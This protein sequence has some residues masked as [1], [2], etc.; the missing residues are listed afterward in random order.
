MYNVIK[1][2]LFTE[3]NTVH[4]QRG[5]YAFEVDRKADKIE[6]RNAVEKLFDVQVTSV[7]TM[8][9]RDTMRSQRLRTDKVRYWKKALVQ[10]AEGEK[11]GL[12][13]GV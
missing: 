12:F 8:V 4:N 2:P 13:E 9:C 3:K 10:V 11:I 1:K 5:V 6:I 7:R